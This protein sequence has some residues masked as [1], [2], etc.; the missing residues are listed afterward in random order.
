MRYLLDT[1]VLSELMRHPNG[2]IAERIRAVGEDQ[3]CTSIIVAAELRYG[4]AKNASPRLIAAL[5]T[6]LS[7]I[8]ILALE[9]P[10]DQ[11]YGTL[12]RELEVAGKPIGA[13]DLLIGAQALS[14]GVVMV[15]DNDGEFGR[16]TG[17][18][19]EN[20]LRSPA[21]S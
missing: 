16:I 8:A 14:A 17:L 15:T 13:N 7:R 18:K 9:P 1:N 20:W 6:V 11:T 2:R 21:S 4:I 12:R 10:A 19:C 3:V 5:E